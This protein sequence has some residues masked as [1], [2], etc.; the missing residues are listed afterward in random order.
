[1]RKCVR[2]LR[3][4]ETPIDQRRERKVRDGAKH[5]LELVARA[6]DQTLQPQTVHER[7]SKIRPVTSGEHTDERDQTACFRGANGL[8]KRA[9]TPDLEHDIDTFSSAE[10]TDFLAP[11]GT[12]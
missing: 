8:R 5:R 10:T 7:G 1:M 9:A 4:A 6:D 11:F 12:R 2:H 3:K